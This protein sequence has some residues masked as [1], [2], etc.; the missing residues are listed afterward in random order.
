M[1]KQEN[2]YCN[3]CSRIYNNAIN[4]FYERLIQ[5]GQG[6]LRGLEMKGHL[7]IILNWLVTFMLVN[8]VLIR[9]RIYS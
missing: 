1:L 3:I 9:L 4:V 2:A 7:G 6:H 8:L 5:I